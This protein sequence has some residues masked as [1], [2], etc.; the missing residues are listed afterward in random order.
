[1]KKN[2][3]DFK[4]L[5][6]G[7]DFAQVIE[8]YG[9]EVKRKGDQHMG[10]CPLPNHNGKRNSPSFSANLK[11]G[12]F[13]CFGCGARGNVLDFAALMEKADPKDGVALRDVAIK[14]Q[15]RFCPES[16]DTA[17]KT[18]KSAGQKPVSTKKAE[19]KDERPVAINQPLDFELKGLDAEHPYLVGRGFTPETIRHFGL[20]YCGRGL[21][22]TRVAIPLHDAD[23]KLVGYAGRVVDDA[24]ISDENPRY[25]F[26]GK[27]ENDGTVFEFRKTQFVY[28]GFRIK[29]PVDDLTVVEGFTGVWW[30]TQNDFPDTVGT[31]GTDCSEQQAELIVSLVKPDGTVWIMPDGDKAGERQAQLLLTL[32]S[33]YRLMRWLKLP[34]GKQPTDLSR[35]KL[36]LKYIS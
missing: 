30:L 21:L 18:D 2:W 25:R 27:R 11:K 29:S 22:K 12:I 34:E 9:V 33:P 19:P 17:G 23:G 36:K 5:R 20:G 28:N 35:E 1:M 3:I 14:L 6:A 31:M 13:Q 16:G 32:I 10:Y 24:A 15:E 7:L 8:H 26:P 4:A